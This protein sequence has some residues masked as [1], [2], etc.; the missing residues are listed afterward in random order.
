MDV[1]SSA[2][3]NATPRRKK[4]RSLFDVLVAIGDAIPG[5]KA[6]RTHIA[7]RLP[8]KYRRPL[9]GVVFVISL[10][11]ATWFGLGNSVVH[12]VEELYGPNVV[13]GVATPQELTGAGQRSLL[14]EFVFSKDKLASSIS[15]DGDVERLFAT[16]A[17]VM[18]QTDCDVVLGERPMR[19]AQLVLVAQNS[20]HK[21]A[22]GYEMM[23]SFS[24]KDLG[25]P[26]PGVRILGVST[27][28]L[29]PGYLYQQDSPAHIGAAIRGCPRL[30][31]YY[32][33]L[34]PAKAAKEK[35]KSSGPEKIPELTR[36]T[37]RAFGLTRDLLILSGT[38]EA[39][40][41]Q[42]ATVVI[43]VPPEVRQ[44]ATVFHIECANCS[45][46]YKTTSFAQLVGV[47]VPLPTG[48]PNAA[49]LP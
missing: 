48:K 14:Y 41:F 34:A 19:L 7:T 30:A 43:A 40:L 46:F 42:V 37:Y 9:L 47:T 49:P 25:R 38:L 36:D 26:D 5:F 31:P 6:F 20:G 13:I 24:S 1:P 18:L 44:F 32:S 22:T 4:H 23:V 45:W 3:E 16:P 8:E 27:D 10:A 15:D 29:Q 28:A 11:G 12:L 33:E 35:E 17:A 39:H 2:P 21:T